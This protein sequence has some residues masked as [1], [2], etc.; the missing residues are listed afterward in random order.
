MPWTMDACAQLQTTYAFL[1]QLHQHFLQRNR[2]A[3]RTASAFKDGTIRTHSY[4]HEDSV[5]S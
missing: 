5:Q 4:R 1:L 3:R 2:F